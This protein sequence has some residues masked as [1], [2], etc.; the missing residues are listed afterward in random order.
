MDRKIEYAI[1]RW[2]EKETAEYN[3]LYSPFMHE[4]NGVKQWAVFDAYGRQL[5]EPNF[6]DPRPS[7]KDEYVDDVRYFTFK[8]SEDIVIVYKETGYTMSSRI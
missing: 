2:S 7:C 3:P 1:C 4:E 8:D 6:S 5:G